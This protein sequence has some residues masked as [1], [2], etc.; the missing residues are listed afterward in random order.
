MAEQILANHQQPA[1]PKS[2]RVAIIEDLRDLREGLQLFLEN[3][4]GFEL[5]GVFGSMEEAL[6]G[7]PTSIPDAILVD[8]GLPGMS[9]I[10]GIRVM[11]E[12]FPDVQLIALTVFDEDDKIFDALC[13]GANGYL[14]KKTPPAKLLEALRDVTSGGAPIS[15]EI[16]S[17][18]IYLFRQFRPPA[19]REACHLTQQETQL[20][21][22]FVDGHNYK[23]A[24][25]E[26]NISVNTISFHLRNI[27]RKLQVHSKSEAVS[28]ALRNRLI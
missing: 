5:T 1:E 12:R 27:Y 4:T 17:R 22:L 7:L 10:E 6:R 3:S 23:T 26:M 21:K 2:I 15:P 24:A 11:K 14:L 25:V 8:L 16:A 19:D 28:K 20:L 13:A 18:V 9:G